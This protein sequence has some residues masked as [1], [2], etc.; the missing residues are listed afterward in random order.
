MGKDKVEIF[1]TTL[2]DGEQV[3]GCKL[4]T[5]QKLIIAERL[6]ELV[7]G[8]QREAL[9]TAGRQ[10]LAALE[11]NDLNIEE[12]KELLQKVIDQERRRQSMSAPTDG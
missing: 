6:D 10:Q 9:R 12:E 5:E 4:D 2:R 7:K 11:N 3:P 1:D 8:F